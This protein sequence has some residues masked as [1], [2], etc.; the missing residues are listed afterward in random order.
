MMVLDKLVCFF[1]CFYV[2]FVFLFWLMG[3]VGVVGDVFPTG[4]FVVALLGGGI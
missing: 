4:I 2:A 1:Y 3:W